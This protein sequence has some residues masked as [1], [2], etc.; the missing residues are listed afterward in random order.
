MHYIT[1]ILNLLIAFVQYK[2]FEEYLYVFNNVNKV[3]KK[4]Y[5][6]NLLR[7]FNCTKNDIK[8][9][10]TL[11]NESLFYLIKCLSNLYFAH[12]QP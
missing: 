8:I 3:I 10:K 7:M 5:I 4:L 1:F 6:V 12:A 9:Y 11:E 2:I